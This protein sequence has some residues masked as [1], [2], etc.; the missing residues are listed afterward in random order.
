MSCSG[1]PLL[2]P[3]TTATPRTRNRRPLGQLPEDEQLLVRASALVARGWCQRAPAENWRGCPVDPRSKTA[4]RWSPLGALTK[5]WAESPELAPDVFRTAWAAL[6][7]ATGGRPKDWSA[8][9]WRTRAHVLRAFER[10]RSSLPEARRRVLQ[11]TPSAHGGNGASETI[12]TTEPRSIDREQAGRPDRQD[13]ARG[14]ERNIAEN[15]AGAD[16]LRGE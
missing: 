7:I 4:V 12:G 2:P 16:S 10:A 5:V 1:L 11:H 15:G 13:E 8:A 6:A 9:Q 3:T 14:S